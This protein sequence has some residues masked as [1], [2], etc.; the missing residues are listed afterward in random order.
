MLC[1]AHDVVFCS[2][3]ITVTHTL[4]ER[5]ALISA[6]FILSSQMFCDYKEIF[7]NFP[8]SAVASFAAADG[9]SPGTITIT[10]PSQ[11][12]NASTYTATLSAVSC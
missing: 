7:Q 11:F 5:S 4:R 6:Q 8:Q 2:G 9:S 3:V 1:S 12:F 10:V